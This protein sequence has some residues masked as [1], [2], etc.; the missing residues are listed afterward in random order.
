MVVGKNHNSNVNSQIVKRLNNCV[1]LSLTGHALADESAV[2]A[3]L[4]R[5]AKRQAARQYSALN[6]SANIGHNWEDLFKKMDF[7]QETGDV[8]AYNQEELIS[9]GDEFSDPRS[10][11]ADKATRFGHHD[12]H[13][14]ANATFETFVNHDR[15][16]VNDV[17]HRHLPWFDSAT[18]QGRFRSAGMCSEERSIL[19]DSRKEFAG[20]NE[21][22]NEEKPATV[23]GKS[24]SVSREEYNRHMRLIS[25]KLSEEK[26]RLQK[27]L[28]QYPCLPRPPPARPGPGTGTGTKRSAGHKRI[29]R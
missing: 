13:T 12:R 22:Q 25:Q 28:Q 7:N 6:T 18:D 10:D 16:P 11:V 29:V 1:T 8:A 21:K 2:A 19:I 14:S 24:P 17:I 9:V 26:L 23:Q 3:A 4:Q 27:Q 20:T 15:R 5:L